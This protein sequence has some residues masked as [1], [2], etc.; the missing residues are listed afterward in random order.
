M[1]RR[2]DA[3]GLQIEVQGGDRLRWKAKRQPP[4]A[5]LLAE[6]RQH[7]AEIIAIL[8]SAPA[9]GP[10]TVKVTRAGRPF[11]LGKV[12]LMAASPAQSSKPTATTDKRNLGYR[13]SPEPWDAA[14]YKTLFDERAAILQFDGGLTPSQA[15]S[16]ALEHC[17][18]EWLNRHPASS[19]AAHCAWCGKPESAGAAVVP[20]GIGERHTWLH[21][22]CWPAWHQQR[23]A[24]ALGALGL[25]GIPVLTAAQPTWS[26]RRRRKQPF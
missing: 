15:E 19:P 3:L 14:D 4:P 2:A 22:H 11:E 10:T 23:R 21:P 6:L 9:E 18:V 13:G 25:M 24:D 12:S 26:V 5:D 1:L 20:F 8:S 7:K 17:V 16:R